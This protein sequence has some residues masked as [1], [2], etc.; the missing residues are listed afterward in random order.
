MFKRVG[1]V[2]FDSIKCKYSINGN[3]TTI[4]VL[5]FVI[6]KT[7]FFSKSFIYSAKTAECCQMHNVMLPI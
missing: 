1:I 6:V 7:F 5:Y 4:F 3:V 2:L